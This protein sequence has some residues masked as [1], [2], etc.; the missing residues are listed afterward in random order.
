MGAETDALTQN[1]VNNRSVTRVGINLVIA[2]QESI[3]NTISNPVDTLPLDADNTIDNTIIWLSSNN[4]S[5]D[6]L[7]PEPNPLSR[8]LT[9]IN[10]GNPPLFWN[11]NNTKEVNIKFYRS[12]RLK[13][14]DPQ[15]YNIKFT[16]SGEPTRDKQRQ[17]CYSKTCQPARTQPLA[18]NT[19]EKR[20]IDNRVL[21]FAF[22]NPENPNMPRIIDWMKYRNVWYLAC[23]YICIGC[24][25]PFQGYD[26][27]YNGSC[28]RCRDNKYVIHNNLDKQHKYI[29]LVPDIRFGPT[30][31][32]K[33][34]FWSSTY[35]V[36]PAIKAK[37]QRSV[38][39]WRKAYIT[40]KSA[41]D[42]NLAAFSALQQAYVALQQEYYNIQNNEQNP[43]ETESQ[44]Q[45]NQEH[46]A[47]IATVQWRNVYA[48]TG[49]D[50]VT[51]HRGSLQ[52]YRTYSE[53]AEGHE[54]DLVHELRDYEASGGDLDAIR[55]HI[56][57]AAS[58]RVWGIFLTNYKS[59]PDTN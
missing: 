57:D 32:G 48:A 26:L 22:N 51:R 46:A 33:N 56:D 58:A 14:Y 52:T 25:L 54:R 8:R 34:S 1:V 23:E 27:E 24:M 53:L 47:L 35:E 4:Y 19:N 49:V 31:N 17:L 21:T 39:T 50:G 36:W 44:L 30:S 10:F 18:F 41:L 38:L 37:P 43:A 28:P 59:F 11:E 2:E 55:Q 20:E 15:L 5:I 3:L 12:K 7:P 40:M 13:Y 42:S 6:R 29:R 45:K 9:T 16:L